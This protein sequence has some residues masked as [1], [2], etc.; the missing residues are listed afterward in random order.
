MTVNRD[1]KSDIQATNNL[2]IQGTKHIL[3]AES[4]LGHNKNCGIIDYLLLKGE[5]IEGLVQKSGRSKSGVIGHIE[6]LKNAHG[7]SISKNN[8]IFKIEYYSY[9]LNKSINEEYFKELIETEIPT[10]KKYSLIKLEKSSKEIMWV[11][12]STKAPNIDNLEVQY[13]DYEKNF[14]Q[15]LMNK[16]TGEFVQFG[17]GFKILSIR[18][19][20]SE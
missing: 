6:H 1:L 14:A 2:I 3:S 20:L 19:F 16:E 7:L 10:I 9:R 17:L 13:L 18:K 15:S 5:S 8:N 12:I 11:S 4:W